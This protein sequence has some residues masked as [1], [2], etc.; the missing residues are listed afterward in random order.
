MAIPEVGCRTRRKWHANAKPL[1]S[2]GQSK[3][4]VANLQRNAQH[5]TSLQRDTNDAQPQVY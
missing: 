5:A 2:F 4:F 3:P 1:I